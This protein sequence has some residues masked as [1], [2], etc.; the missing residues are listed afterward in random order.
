MLKKVQRWFSSRARK[1]RGELLTK[2]L[3]PQ[4]TD[5]ILDL[6]GGNGIHIHSIL[7]KGFQ[8]TIA[9][10]LEHDLKYARETFG[11]KTIKLTEEKKLP[12]KDKSFDIVF[13]NSVLEH[14][15]LP[16]N[17]IWDVTDSEIFKRESLKSQKAF[18]EEIKRI[19]K[20]Y[21]VQTPHKYFIIESHTWLPVLIVILPRFIQLKVI[22][23]FNSFWPKKTAPDWNLLTVSQMKSIFPDAEIHVERVFGIPKSIIA[24]KR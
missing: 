24:I 10:I 3:N 6:G 19:S 1:K 12:F 15:T 5:E 18:A 2:T 9:D 8:I 13:C 7:G 21:F 23:F 14:V 11:N 16:K 22:K 4:H 17:Q 20:K